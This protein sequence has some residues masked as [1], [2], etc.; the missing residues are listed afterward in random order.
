MVDLEQLLM[1]NLRQAGVICHA[2]PLLTIAHLADLDAG[3]P[4]TLPLAKLL[5]TGYPNPDALIQ[6]WQFFC[7]SADYVWEGKQY[8]FGMA[9]GTYQVRERRLERFRLETRDDVRWKADI[10]KGCGKA[11]E[12]ALN[13]L[14]D[15]FLGL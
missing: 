13:R 15:Y 12:T 2:R 11:C 8:G 9:R 1:A 14:V 4:V 7:E 10:L 6:D 5:L 3:I